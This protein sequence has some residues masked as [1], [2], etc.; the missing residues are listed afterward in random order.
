MNV[1]RCIC[2]LL[3]L[4]GNLALAQPESTAWDIL[5]QGIDDKNPDRRKQAVTAIGS[6]GLMPEAVKLVEHGL[7]DDDPIVRQVGA[8][9]LGQMKST[10]S[11][12]ALIA[13]LDDPSGEVQFTA[14]RALW[15]M[16]DH[17]GETVLQD[18]MTRQQKATLGFVEGGMRDAKAKLRDKKG[19]AKMGIN[20]ASGALLGPFSIGVIAA[21]EMLKDS[22]ATGRA[23]S[24]TLL[25]QKCDSR[26]IQLLQWTLKEEKNNTVR[27]VV[28]KSLGQCGTAEDIV[29]IE[30]YLSA[31]ND[32]LKFMAA[33]AIIRLSRLPQ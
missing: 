29:R 17:S 26:N 1:K 2:L 7:R 16:G 15:E 20:E 22:G 24:A 25:A 21:E 12:P 28:A 3:M 23:L 5:R 19:L 18:V 30:P 14:A 4:S 13:A 9:V 27:A 31:G 8:A 6:L 11:I 33:A 10:S 32:A